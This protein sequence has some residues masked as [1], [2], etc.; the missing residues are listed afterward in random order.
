MQRYPVWRIKLLVVGSVYMA[1]VASAQGQV[2][3]FNAGFERPPVISPPGILDDPTAEQQGAGA[4]DSPWVFTGSAGIAAAG[5]QF[6]RLTT[7]PPP[8]GSQTGF[9]DVGGLFVQ[10]L[11]FP[12]TGAY[13]LSYQEAGDG[14]Y[15]VKLDDAVIV[16][17]HLTS[18]DFTPINTSF[19]ASAGSHKLTFVDTDPREIAGPL[20]AF[21]DQVVVTPEPAWCGLLLP[22]PLLRRKRVAPA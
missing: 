7:P 12:A 14:I 18:S 8:E 6:A 13:T 4:G 22:A 20:P 10:S 3:V 2:Q 15:S 17:S 1:V 9:V 16:A 11:Q 21:I 19:E 5:S